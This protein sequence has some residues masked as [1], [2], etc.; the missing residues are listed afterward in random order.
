MSTLLRLVAGAA[1]V[2]FAILGMAMGM[3]KNTAAMAAPAHLL[4]FLAAL[5]VYVVPSGLALHRNCAASAWIVAVN[6]LLGWT[7]FGWVVAL[8]WAVSGKVAVLPPA[9]PVR[10][11]AGH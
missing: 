7:L 8:G 6:L 2:A 5:A 10:P 4:L 9:P 11:L 1:L 3:A